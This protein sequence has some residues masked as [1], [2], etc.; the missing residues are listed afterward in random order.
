LPIRIGFRR[1]PPLVSIPPKI[2]EESRFENNN[3]EVPDCLSSAGGR[4]WRLYTRGR[5]SCLLEA[6]SA[7][8]RPALRR[9]ERNC[10]LH[11]ALRANRPRLSPHARTGAC[12][13]L[14]LA[15]FTALGIVLEL[16][17]VKE[18]L[19]SGCEN[20]ITSAIYAIQHLVDELHPR[21]PRAAPRNTKEATAPRRSPTGRTAW[22]RS[23]PLLS[24]E[25]PWPRRRVAALK[26]FANRE[27]TQDGTLLGM[28][29][30]QIWELQHTKNWYSSYTKGPPQPT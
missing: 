1:N 18:K 8:N 14:R 30:A 4:H 27:E 11:L 7:Q 28:S 24:V 10:R 19:F 20:E 15:L 25:G 6:G 26:R 16:L 12:S 5:W 29:D 13:P 21:V 17:I 23:L 2:A 22:C 9:L 3:S